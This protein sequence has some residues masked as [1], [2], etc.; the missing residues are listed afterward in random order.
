[1]LFRSA[2]LRPGAG[3]KVEQHQATD[4]Q[5]SRRVTGCVEFRRR[6][7]A[8]RPALVFIEISGQVVLGCMLEFRCY[9]ESVASVV[10]AV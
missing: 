10:V 8:N 2:A 7:R 3:D 6:R 9:R 4:D 1:M 5:K